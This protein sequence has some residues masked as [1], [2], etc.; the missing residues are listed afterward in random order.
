[1]E[2]QRVPLCP[3]SPT[4]RLRLPV[5]GARAR[6]CVG[7]RAR[8]R[9]PFVDTA[10][11]IRAVC[12]VGVVFA[13]CCAGCGPPSVSS[14][15][16]GSGRQPDAATT[17]IDAVASGDSSSSSLLD[18]GAVDSSNCDRECSAD[19]H[20]VLDCNGTVIEECPPEQGCANGY[21]VAACESARI[22]ESTIGC[23][24]YAVVPDSVPAVVGSCFAA[25]VANTW[26]S[27]VTITVDRDGQTLDVTHFARIPAGSGQRL[28]YTR[29]PDGQLPP[30]GVAILFLSRFGEEGCDCPDGVTPA[31]TAVDPAVHGTGI[32]KAFHITTSAPVVAY[33]IFPFGG[34][35]SAATSATLLIPTSAWGTNYMAVDAYKKGEASIQRTQPVVAIV[36]AEDHTSVTIAPVAAIEGG[37]DVE[38]ALARTPKSYHLS[39]GEVLQFAQ[40]A[41]LAGSPI[42]SNRPIGVWSGASC[43]NI[44]VDKVACDTA[45]QQ[46]SPIKS[47]GN[48]YAAVRYRN[49]FDDVE[50]S[51]P[52]RL[53]GAV[54]DTQLSYRPAIPPGAPRSIAKGEV[55]ELNS[56]GPFIVE[57]QDQDHP[58]YMAAYMT[59]CS[60]VN[61]DLDDCRG[62]PEY[63]NVIPVEQYLSRY[64]FFT[65]PTY[66]ETN[67]VLIRRKTPA[68]FAEVT[69]DCAGVVTGWKPIDSLDEYEYA[70]IDLVR[71]DFEPQGGC[72]NGLHE[73]WS[74]APF[75]VTVWGWGSIASEPFFS[76]AVSYAYPAGANIRHIN[77]IYVPPQL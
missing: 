66:P 36:A 16:D 9:Y 62:D 27:P 6:R 64:T 72:D 25:F 20:S 52:W 47:L 30:G 77:E 55:A 67:L 40:D 33:D 41:E 75:G 34:G 37:P 70:R 11:A 31:V 24:Y 45:H 7:Q 49:R 63:V 50:E 59:G 5:T 76:R 60:T 38:G 17:K 51:P 74:D 28:A 12:V 29:L 57:S 65:D 69:L 48:R 19:L 73:I 4:S 61:P 32:G 35:Q 56:A 3:E 46:I 68:G 26:G 71:G 39:R 14:P 43:I 10:G 8:H 15:M 44:P 53:V 21:C 54:D 18:G 23:D 2:K 58:F 42:E 13:G 22:I 1:M